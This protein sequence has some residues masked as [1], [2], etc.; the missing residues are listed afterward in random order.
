[1]NQDGKG[2]PAR[3]SVGRSIKMVAWSFV[4]IRKGSEL[5]EDMARVSPFQVI[6]V[7]IGAAVVFVLSLIAL[8]HWVVAK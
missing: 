6:A 7:G 4:G 2:V 8:V 5:Q 1:M 3:L